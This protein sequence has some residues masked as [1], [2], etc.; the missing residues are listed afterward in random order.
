MACSHCHGAPLQQEDGNRLQPP[1]GDHHMGLL[2]IDCSS[3]DVCAGRQPV[4]AVRLHGCVQKSHGATVLGLAL[5]H[6]NFVLMA[7]FELQLIE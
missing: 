3:H 5:R 6:S 4:L 2:D 7:S 1:H